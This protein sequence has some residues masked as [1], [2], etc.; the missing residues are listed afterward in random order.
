MCVVVVAVE[1]DQEVA[2]KKELTVRNGRRETTYQCFDTFRY[3][4]E[5]AQ[6]RIG[7]SLLIR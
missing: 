3:S 1:N 7:C 4:A 6:A 5:N 2:P